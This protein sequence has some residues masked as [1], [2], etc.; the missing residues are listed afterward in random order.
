MA[1]IPCPIV[2]S[3]YNARKILVDVPDSEITLD[4]L[5]TYADL[6][7]ACRE[8]GG[9][10]GFA[11]LIVGGVWDKMAGQDRLLVPQEGGADVDGQGRNKYQLKLF[12]MLEVHATTHHQPRIH[13][14][15]TITPLIPHLPQMPPVMHGSSSG[16][17]FDW[18]TLSLGYSAER[19]KKFLARY[20]TVAMSARVGTRSARH[21]VARNVRVRQVAWFAGP[22]PRPCTGTHPKPRPCTGTHTRTLS[23]PCSSTHTRAATSRT[24]TDS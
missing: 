4:T 5:V 7:Q 1:Y 15:T 13:W 20:V 17:R 24:A 6:W 11:T 8:G 9:D 22:K 23:P 3:V 12:R 10:G 2:S 18:R 19:F 16:I 21:S 14:A